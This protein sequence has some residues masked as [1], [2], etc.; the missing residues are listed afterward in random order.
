VE[1]PRLIESEGRRW[2]TLLPIVAV[3][4]AAL[5]VVLTVVQVRNLV[6]G[7]GD[8]AAGRT[9]DR[10]GPVLLQSMRDLSRYEAAAGTFQVVVDLE[11]D[12]GFLPQAVVGQRT[13]FVAI[14]TVD[15]YVD[16]SRLGD[17]A[18]TVS[19]D[20]RSVQVR[21]PHA[22]LDRPNLDHQR[23]YVFAEERGIV[24]RIRAF[25]DQSPN[26]QAE[27]YQVAERKIGEAAAQ[28]GL[29]DRADANTRTMLRDM[30][31]ALGYQ[32]VSI[33]YA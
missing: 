6:Q 8:R 2:R 17:D 12:A 13:L 19:A 21:L 7:L 23:S 24:D 16:F 30:L 15:A 10:S 33:T 26:E 5:V 14:G 18:L 27:L 9:V 31:R 11:K 29:T 22:A 28:S 25:F 3:L 1:G 4:L 32:Q 20:R